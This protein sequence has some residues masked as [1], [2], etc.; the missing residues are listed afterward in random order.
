MPPKKKNGLK[1]GATCKDMYDNGKENPTQNLNGGIAVMSPV[2][3]T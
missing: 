3:A 1:Q 2:V